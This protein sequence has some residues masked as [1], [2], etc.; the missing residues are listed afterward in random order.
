MATG[1]LL[2][3]QSCAQNNDTR[4]GPIATEENTAANETAVPETSASPAP[5]SSPD[6][7]SEF[8][9]ERSAKLTDTAK[10]LAG[11]KVEQTSA[12][13]DVQKRSAWSYNADSFDQ[14]WKR[15]E[16]QQISKVRQ[17]AAA[18]LNSLNASAPQVFYPFSGPDFLYIY[19]FLPDAREY[20]LVGL[21]PV[22]SLPDLEKL[23]ENQIDI[24]MQA[25]AKSVDAILQVSYFLTKEMA[26]DLAQQGVVP[27]LLVFMARS[28]NQILDVQYVGLGKDAQVKVLT[29]PANSQE[30]ISGV[31]ISFLPEGK[32]NPR[33]LYYFS[34]DLSDAGLQQTPQFPEFVKTLD[35]PVTYFKAASYLTHYPEFAAIRD[36]VL[37]QSSSVLQDDSGIPLRYF[38]SSAWEMK[39][40]GNYI[41]PIPLFAEFYQQKLRDIYVSDSQVK[42]IDFGIGYMFG[43]GSHLM[44]MTAKEQ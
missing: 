17:W 15:L 42:P 21:E 24:Q 29:E 11:M 27:I 44:L 33:T 25:I 36:L 6:P 38:D 31:K 12:I 18:E 28:N 5:E 32:S 43:E 1:V 35:E 16:S 26:V 2:L 22:G 4:N 40:Y 30:M 7:L 20:V 10:L 34:T 37:A 41:Q 39:F 23:S 3:L 13:A 9:K 14:S 19:S 8:D